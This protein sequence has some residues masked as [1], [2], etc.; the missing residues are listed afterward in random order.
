MP[1]IMVPT[2]PSSHRT[3]ANTI[4]DGAGFSV[5]AA[6]AVEAV[7]RARAVF[8]YAAAVAGLPSWPLA[9]VEAQ[10]ER[11]LEIELARLRAT[12]VWTA[13]S[14]RRFLGAW[15]RKTGRPSVSTRQQAG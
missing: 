1:P 3:P 5:Q 7:A 9:R 15:P 12:P 13:G 2:A 10:T 6:D 8:E 4:R 14:V 11:E